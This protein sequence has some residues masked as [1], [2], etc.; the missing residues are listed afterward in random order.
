MTELHL[1]EQQLAAL[2][3]AS[4]S[5]AER[6]FLAEHLRTCAGCHEAYRDA[7]R[8]RAILLAD[9]S[10]FR[11]PD[12]AVELARR[13]ARPKPA[14]RPARPRVRWFNPRLVAGLSAAAILVTAAVLWKSGFT[15]RSEYDRYIMPLQQAAAS[16]SAEGSIVMP[17]VEESVSTTSTLHRTGFVQTDDAITTALDGLK[18]AYR[19][20]ANAEV[21]HW[22]ISGYL[23]TG[24]IES[25]RLY[26]QDARIQFP[27]DTRFLVLD[28]IIAYRSSEMDRAERLLRDALDNDPHNGAAMLNLA[29]VQYEMGQWDSARRTLE[30]V[31]SQFAGSPLETRASTLITDLLNG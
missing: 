22:L 18:E 6:A 3:D 2:A 1:T 31:R 15:P 23:A 10:V 19:E 25:A 5:E 21:A 4:I 14:E 27:E 8:Y 17:G 29:L 26:V 9:A 11:A 20:D 12:E 7:V 28:A 30:L 13:I 16:A 24:E